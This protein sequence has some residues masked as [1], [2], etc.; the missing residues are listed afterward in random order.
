[1][2]SKIRT[3]PLLS[4]RRQVVAG[5]VV[6]DEEDLAASVLGCQSLQERPESLSI[7][8]IGKPI[9]EARLDEANRGKQVGSLP[10]TI[11]VDPWL[12]AEARPRSVQRAVE[13]EA[14]LVLEKDYP[15]TGGRLFFI[16]GNVV[17]SQYACRS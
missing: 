13:P 3:E 8:D 15:A 16:P 2:L 1:M 12:T 10:L 6:D 11:C 4:F 9:G 17:R 7:E 5:C 14:G